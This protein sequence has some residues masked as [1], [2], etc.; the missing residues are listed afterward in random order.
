MGNEQTLHSCHCKS[1]SRSPAN[2][3][4]VEGRFA[5]E[6]AEPDGRHQC[7]DDDMRIESSRDFTACDRIF[8]HPPG[9]AK[10][11][12]CGKGRQDF[13]W[14][15]A[16]ALYTGQRLGDCLAMRWSAINAGGVIAVTQ[17]KTGKALLIPI[18][19]RLAGVLLD[20]IPRRAVDP[21]QYRRAAVAR[22]PGVLAQTHA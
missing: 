6:H 19:K 2:E 21:D 15:A 4:R 7:F 12:L 17:A 9:P 22:L 3:C 18:H 5:H 8:K 20:G 14:A 11:D 13:W 10:S 1:I 16:L